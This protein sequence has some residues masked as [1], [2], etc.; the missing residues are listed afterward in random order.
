MSF[1][2]YSYSSN[3][4]RGRHAW[5]SFHFLRCRRSAYCCK[6][7]YN[8]YQSQNN[9]RSFQCSW[10]TFQVGITAGVTFALTVFA[11]QTKIDFTACG[12]LLLVHLHSPDSPDFNS[13]FTSFS[14][15]SSSTPYY[16]P[17]PHFPFRSAAPPQSRP[18]PRPPPQP[19]PNPA[20]QPIPPR[21]ALCLAC[22][23]HDRWHRLNV[24]PQGE[25]RNR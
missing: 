22:Y 14:F 4:L 21:N 18:D 3:S 6:F 23:L 1:N 15:S 25:E 24:S 20:H 10:S 2:F 7:S 9:Y 16:P 11:F 12:G 19:D 17:C 13:F 5:N 8:D